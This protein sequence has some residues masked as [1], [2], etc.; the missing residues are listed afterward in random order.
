M[1]LSLSA[2]NRQQKQLGRWRQVLWYLNYEQLF[3]L[4][5][6]FI[7]F[8]WQKY[9]SLTMTKNLWFTQNNPWSQICIC[10]NK[11]SQVQ[12]NLLVTKIL[13]LLTWTVA[14]N[15]HLPLE[16]WTWLGTSGDIREHLKPLLSEFKFPFIVRSCP[17][18]WQCLWIEKCSSEMGERVR[19]IQLCISRK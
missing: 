12:V 6:S 5:W 13:D 8:F 15:S 14:Y 7:F 19:L 2:P 10:F 1:T 16:L 18:L 11:K 17:G 3:Q 9:L 4:G